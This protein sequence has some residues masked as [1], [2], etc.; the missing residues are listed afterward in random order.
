LRVERERSPADLRLATDGGGQIRYLAHQ[1]PSLN[2][3]SVS[4]E[5]GLSNDRSRESLPAAKGRLPPP[6]ARLGRQ[7]DRALL[8]QKA[9][10][11]DEASEGC[12]RPRSGHTVWSEAD[13]IW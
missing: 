9:T 6:V 2:L 12:F 4:P 5:C 11:W 13:V 7:G 3:A 8:G 1:P 10:L